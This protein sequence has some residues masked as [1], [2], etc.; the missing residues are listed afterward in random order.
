MGSHREKVIFGVLGAITAIIVGLAL[1]HADFQKQ[2]ERGPA[3]NSEKIEF[4]PY[5]YYFD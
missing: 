3:S 1:F 5:E 4:H 2:M